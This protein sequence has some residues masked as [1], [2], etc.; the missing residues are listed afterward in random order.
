MSRLAKIDLVTCGGFKQ[1][2]LCSTKT[3]LYREFIGISFLAEKSDTN[4]QNRAQ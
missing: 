1:R 2:S 4:N 3:V